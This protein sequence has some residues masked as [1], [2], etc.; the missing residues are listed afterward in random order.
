MG[1]P[2]PATALAPADG[3]TAPDTVG[4][5]PSSAA[6]LVALTARRDHARLKRNLAAAFV[7]SGGGAGGG[8]VP[9]GTCAA[10]SLADTTLPGTAAFE[11][12]FIPVGEE[13]AS[14]QDICAGLGGTGTRDALAALAGRER[15]LS[16][17]AGSETSVVRDMIRDYHSIMQADPTCW[18]APT[19]KPTSWD[20]AR[21]RL[22]DFD[23]EVSARQTRRKVD[24]KHHS[25]HRVQSLGDKP[26]EEAA[27][28]AASHLLLNQLTQQRAFS[29][30]QL[31]TPKVDPVAE[32]ARVVQA[33]GAPGWAAIF[34]SLVS[35]QRLSGSSSADGTA[36]YAL[37]PYNIYRARE[38]LARWAG[39]VVGAWNGVDRMDHG[40]GANPLLIGTSKSEGA[41]LTKRAADWTVQ[42]LMGQVDQ[43]EGVF[44]L[45]GEES[46]AGSG[47]D[48]IMG[49]SPTLGRPGAA[50]G[51]ATYEADFEKFLTRIEFLIGTIFGLAGG[52]ELDPTI[53]HTPWFGLA[54]LPPDLRNPAVA[55]AS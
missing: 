52:G 32:A 24:G 10:T 19:G 51:G 11:L 36:S 31:A 45:G 47:T 42:L 22:N 1:L 23:A 17:V 9:M 15:R 48:A 16:M 55:H 50:P 27:F 33:H 29:V 53:T 20:D 43:D 5:S 6:A 30:E 8:Q 40:T 14:I 34:S 49:A 18:D 39:G 35:D 41:I 37:I 25:T 13:H 54:P 4:L 46:Q 7:A 2:P 44:L 26:A 38:G 12:S 28:Q 21:D 3:S